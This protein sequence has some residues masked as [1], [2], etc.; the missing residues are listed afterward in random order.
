MKKL[1]SSNKEFYS[2]DNYVPNKRAKKV[3][4]KGVEYLSKAQCMALNNLTK[5]ELD[6]YL[7]NE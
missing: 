5:K 4:Y 1:T 7:K 2:F 6:E 3:T